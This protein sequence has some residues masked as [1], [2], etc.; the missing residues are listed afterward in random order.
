[1]F[2]PFFLQVS[3]PVTDS[4]PSAITAAESSETVFDLMLKGGPVMIPLAILLF[5]TIFLLIERYLTISKAGKMDPN[6]M[7]NIRDA[8][9]QGNLESAKTLARTTTSPTARMIEKG[10]LRIGKPLD[11]IHAAIENVGKLEVAKLEKGLAALATIAGAAPMLGFL[12]TVTGM[13]NAF[14][15]IANSETVITPALLASGIYEAMVTT[16]AGLVIGLLAYLGYNALT[17]MVENI[18]YRMEA[19]SME[20]IDLLQEPA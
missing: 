18:V 4:L 5:A 8:V 19:S 2:Q 11:D 10:I 15:S 3:A 13:V 6:F 1:M 14:R 17:V 12:G 16:V 9:L 7:R 20:F